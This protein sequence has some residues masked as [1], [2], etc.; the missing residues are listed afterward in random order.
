MSSIKEIKDKINEKLKNVDETIQLLE[1]QYKPRLG[2]GRCHL[3]RVIFTIGILSADEYKK[4]KGA[5]LGSPETE[6]VILEFFGQTEQIKCEAKILRKKIAARK[7]AIAANIA[8]QKNNFENRKGRI[9][10][11]KGIK[12][13]FEPWNKGLT[14]NDDVRLLKISQNKTGSGNPMFGKTIS[15]E[16][17]EK[18]SIKIKQKIANGEWT[19]NTF[20]SRTRK[21][22]LFRKKLFRSSWEALFYSK[23]E[24]QYEKIRIPYIDENGIAHNF[25]TD[26]FDEKTNTIFE[27]KPT[28]QVLIKKIILE[29]VEDWC[30]NNG[31]KFVI[32]TEKELVKLIPFETVDFDEFDF[33]T[34]RLIKGLY[35]TDKK[36]NN[37]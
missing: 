29:K 30:N 3:L 18:Q 8:A 25:I 2:S 24:F 27:I 12:G 31:Y 10:W 32:I 20:N 33:N 22:L 35:E 4:F 26:F 6:L 11:N 9:P 19:P 21:K 5:L 1:F 16:A 28:K 34:Q 14:K 17:R 15:P 23:F 36:R 37:I 7:G 13:N